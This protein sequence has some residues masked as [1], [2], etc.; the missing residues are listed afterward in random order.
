MTPDDHPPRPPDPAAEPPLAPQDEEAS[1][2]VD[3][4]LDDAGAADARRS[5]DVG[6]RA[7]AMEAARTA[8][9]D[10]PPADPSARDRAVA[11]ARAAFDEE[12]RGAV[13]QTHT[14]PSR[15]RPSVADIGEHRRRR[16]ATGR[17]LGAAA[18]A[19]L[20]VGVLIAGLVSS[21]SD[22]DASDNATAALDTAESAPGGDSEESAESTPDADADGGEVA[23]DSPAEAPSS[24]SAAARAVLGSFPDAEALL[25]AAA[26]EPAAQ[27]GADGQDDRIAPAYGA[28][29]AL[30]PEGPPAPFADGAAG[31][32]VVASGEVDGVSVEVWRTGTG[33]AARL[34]ALDPTCAVLADRP[35]P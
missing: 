13:D 4:L 27:A 22:Q 29:A 25:D 5:P 24:G 32:A 31:A 18:A 15:P 6:A 14:A 11:A 7:A 9:R 8:L 16:E 10:V 26:A 28:L 19:V 3:G 2:L 12:A 20:L 1:A 17:W 30:C 35:L 21:S 34:V 23:G 33:D